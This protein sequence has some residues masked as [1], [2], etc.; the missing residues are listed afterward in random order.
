MNAGAEVD[1]GLVEELVE[2]A[3]RANH[4]EIV[5]HIL[6]RASKHRYKPPK[7]TLSLAIRNQIVEMMD[8]LLNS[9]A[10]IGQGLFQELVAEAVRVNNNEIVK[11]FLPRAKRSY[12]I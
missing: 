9:G 4:D 6:S 5:K 7:S 10:A 12:T 1:R 11:H 3:V 2:E 8:L